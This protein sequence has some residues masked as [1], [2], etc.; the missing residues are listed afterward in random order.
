MIGHTDRELAGDWS[1]ESYLATD[2]RV[3]RTGEPVELE[4][5]LVKGDTVLTYLTA[6][7][8]LRDDTGTSTAWAGS[9][10]TSPSASGSRGIAVAKRQALA[11]R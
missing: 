8:P 7:F 1:V 4:E 2:A 3:L 11:A 5:T 10:P 9:P 6:K